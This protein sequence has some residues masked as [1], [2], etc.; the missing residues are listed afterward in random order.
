MKFQKLLSFVLSLVMVLTLLSFALVVPASADGAT[1]I[2]TAA[3]FMQ[4]KADGS[5]YLTDDLF[6][7]KE[8]GDELNTFTGIFDGRG[9]TVTVKDCPLFYYLGGTAVVKNLTI[10][11]SVARAP[12]AAAVA[13]YTSGGTWFGIR[14]Q[15]ITNNANITASQDGDKRSY[16]GGLIADA[17]CPNG[18][19]TLTLINCT[20][21]GKISG[22]Q[23]TYAA[24]GLVG[25]W[26]S[27]RMTV[28]NCINTGDVSAFQFAGGLFG[29]VGLTFFMTNPDSPRGD[30]VIRN[31]KNTG[32][33]SNRYKWYAAGLVGMLMGNLKVTN[34]TNEGNVIAADG[35]YG[36]AGIVG[37]FYK[38]DDDISQKNSTTSSLTLL[39]CLNTGTISG[40]DYTGAMV[41]LPQN[42]DN[43]ST[44]N[45]SESIDKSGNANFVGAAAANGTID[46]SKTEAQI[47]KLG[48]QELP[49][50]G[51]RS[52]LSGGAG[53]EANPYLVST[54]EDLITLSTAVGNSDAYQDVYLRMTA[55]IDLTGSDFYPIGNEFYTFNGIFDGAGHTVKGLHI[56]S[57]GGEAVGLFGAISGGATVKN[58]KVKGDLI[59]SDYAA[60]AIAGSATEGAKIFNCSSEI[61]KI[62]GYQCGGIVG[63]SQG[64]GSS[65]N[66][67]VNCESQ[68]GISS[69]AGSSD[70]SHGGIAGIISSSVVFGCVNDGS[71][72]AEI[73]AGNAV[74][75]IVGTMKQDSYLVGCINKETI[76]AYTS[77]ESVKI[78]AA[79]IA[80]KS[81]GLI[82]RCV[83][84]GNVTA[85]IGNNN[86]GVAA[87]ISALLPSDN[88]AYIDQCQCFNTKSVANFPE[89]FCEDDSAFVLNGEPVCASVLENFS[90][91]ESELIDVLNRMSTLYQFSAKKI[92]ILNE[93]CNG[94]YYGY[95]SSAIAERMQISGTAELLSYNN[96][97]CVVNSNV[98]SALASSAPE[99][100]R[101]ISVLQ[102]EVNDMPTPKKEAETTT[103][104]EESAPAQ[105]QEN[106]STKTTT[107]KQGCRGNI[108]ATPVV[109]LAVLPLAVILCKKKKETEG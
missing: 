109:L 37:G 108:I 13:F 77:E 74:G 44:L 46:R 22:T 42:K 57:S 95:V 40:G 45:I 23:G 80:G 69:L 61:T 56:E 89:D 96:G 33:I 75:G 18:E 68:S 63:V 5:Y 101:L 50:P 60:G 47:E 2:S 93:K 53:T 17:F 83:N 82:Y 32:E 84:T 70:Y 100:I 85:L 102:N 24:G 28:V 51:E 55:D 105:T 54:S 86:P 79:G 4:M 35:S 92:A 15:N 49:T 7:T 26:R 99:I 76:T 98:G 71:V 10:E 65:W 66:Y 38:N 81:S 39:K 36:S 72:Q 62:E 103:S 14:L 21:N 30:R 34:C 59:R 9:H 25:F 31:C 64:S 27:E 43:D 1:P 29:R 58:L 94:D 48:F 104:E 41:A 88:Y 52:A 97:T 91:R 8:W 67:I 73:T 12:A 90:I 3:E 107:K 78:Y 11:G 20:N 6:I 16:A 19:C 106:E 87:G